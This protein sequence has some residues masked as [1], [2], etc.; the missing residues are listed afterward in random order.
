M[1]ARVTQATTKSLGARTQPWLSL[2]RSM[3]AM[4]GPIY[5]NLDRRSQSDALSD[6][7]PGHRARDAGINRRGRVVDTGQISPDHILGDHV[8]WGLAIGGVAAQKHVGTHRIDGQFDLST[9]RPRDREAAD[10]VRVD[11]D[12]SIRRPEQHE[13]HADRVP[14]ILSVAPGETITLP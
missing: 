10:N 5:R 14:S 13:V 3:P 4:Q 11:N 8:I 6:F 1:A 12:Y 2:S 7:V 9:Q